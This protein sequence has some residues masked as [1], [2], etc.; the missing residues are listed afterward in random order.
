MRRKKILYKGIFSFTD[1]LNLKRNKMTNYKK[2]LEAV[3]QLL[4]SWV[5]DKE[6]TYQY[7]EDELKMMLIQDIQRKIESDFVIMTKEEFEKRI[8]F[9]RQF[10]N[11]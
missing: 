5:D 10:Y 2:T 11:Y 4:N 9:E 1:E 3:K 8:E 6:M 7:S